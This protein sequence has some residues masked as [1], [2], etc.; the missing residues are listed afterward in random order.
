[1]EG[2]FLVL[3]MA[4]MVPILKADMDPI[5]HTLDMALP[6][7]DLVH[8][9]YMV[10]TVPDLLVNMDLHTADPVCMDM[11]LHMLDLDLA[12]KTAVMANCIDSFVAVDRD[13]VL[14]FCC[15]LFFPHS[16]YDSCLYL[17]FQYF[18]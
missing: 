17:N 6:M 11:G 18:K 15:D 16:Y 9:L 1:M 10:D 12:R 3:H 7:L 2:M 8:L 13:F 4:D 5:S 14:I